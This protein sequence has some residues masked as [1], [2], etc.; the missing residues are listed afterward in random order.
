ML[1]L[2]KF[3]LPKWLCW[4][5]RSFPLWIICEWILTVENNWCSRYIWC[6]QEQE[7]TVLSMR[8]NRV[9]PI[10]HIKELHWHRLSILAFKD[11][12]LQIRTRGQYCIHI[13]PVKKY[14]SLWEKVQ[15]S[16]KNTE[17]HCM[18]WPKKK[19]KKSLKLEW[20]TICGC[21]PLFLLPL[22]QMES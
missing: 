2:H 20:F 3:I 7:A 18:I 19:K 8:P 10:I 15:V 1:Y 5:T 12:T 22:C 11:M 9:I 17:P 14:F 16:K 21:L 4:M 13:I 6:A